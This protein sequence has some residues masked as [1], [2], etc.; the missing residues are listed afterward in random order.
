MR[1]LLLIPVLA[2]AVVPASA[3]AKH[4]G[5]NAKTVSGSC[6][7]GTLSQLCQGSFP[8][9]SASTEEIAGSAQELA[10]TAED[11]AQLVGTFRLAN[12]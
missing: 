9:P 5:S 8:T 6:T 3:A 10:T 11:L 2:L 4:G 1:H 12:A 7:A